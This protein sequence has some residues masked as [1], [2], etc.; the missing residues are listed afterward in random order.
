MTELGERIREE[1]RKRRLTLQQFGERAGLSKSFLS[2]VERGLTEPSVSSLKKIAGQFGISVVQLF[3][4]NKNGRGKM[5]LQHFGKNKLN[6]SPYAED[7]NVIRANLRK[8]FKLPAS[9]ITYDLLT[10]DLRRKL[11]ILFVRAEPG[12]HSG[13]EPMVNI[14]GEKFVLL[15]KGKLE[16]TVR[17]EVFVLNQGDTIYHPAHVP[18]SWRCLGQ[19][20]AEIILVM[21]PPSF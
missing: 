1:R 12:E 8:R 17:D 6:E 11:E 9:N 5:L 19:E 18:H 2:Q 16:I 7:V 13:D 10:P 14:P 3:A 4:E 20:S 15:L 21:T